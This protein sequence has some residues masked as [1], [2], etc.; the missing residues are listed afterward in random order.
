MLY[1]RHTT[2]VDIFQQRKQC[3]S[4]INGSRTPKSKA[5]MCPPNLQSPHISSQEVSKISL[6]CGDSQ[7]SN[8]ETEFFFIVYSNVGGLQNAGSNCREQRA[9]WDYATRDAGQNAPLQSQYIQ[10]WELK[11]LL[12]VINFQMVS[13]YCDLQTLLALPASQST[14]AIHRRQ[15]C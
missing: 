4:K 14:P 13:V 6:W 3:P 8:L 12:V 5:C 2:N 10:I 7:R 9:L 11:I 15:R 1:P